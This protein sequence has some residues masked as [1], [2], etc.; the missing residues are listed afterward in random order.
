MAQDSVYSNTL[1]QA[2]VILGGDQQL[3]R[4]LRVPL[5]DLQYWLAGKEEPPRQVFLRAVDVVL[6]GNP[7]KKP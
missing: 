3:A 2:G 1:R 4:H 7:R 5:A 6:E